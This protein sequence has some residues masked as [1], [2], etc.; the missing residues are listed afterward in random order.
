MNTEVDYLI[1]SPLSREEWASNSNL[2]ELL[3]ELGIRISRDPDVYEV[4]RR[5]REEKWKDG[6]TDD[7][8]WFDK[9]KT[10]VLVAYPSNTNHV[11]VHPVGE[12]GE[13]LFNG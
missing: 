12:A 9:S 11:T 1:R 4:I 8:V 3:V 2:A 13:K 10:A 7:K 5:V 6:D